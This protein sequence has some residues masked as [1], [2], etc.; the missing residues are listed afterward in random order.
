MTHEGRLSHSRTARDYGKNA[1]R[2]KVRIRVK[3]DQSGGG[4]IR[5]G[6]RRG[7]REVNVRDEIPNRLRSRLL[8]YVLGRLHDVLIAFL[9]LIG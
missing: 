3:V 4:I 5:L 2:E 6:H 8:Y 7:G 1:R 9:D